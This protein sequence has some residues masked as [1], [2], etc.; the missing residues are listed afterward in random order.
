LGPELKKAGYDAVFVSGASDKPVYLWIKDGQAE[1]RD[2][3][4]LWGLDAS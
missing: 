4:K 2:A 1:L 3:G